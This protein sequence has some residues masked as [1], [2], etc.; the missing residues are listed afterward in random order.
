MDLSMEST[1][2]LVVQFSPWS[3]RGRG[4]FVLLIGLAGFLYIAVHYHISCIEK[5][6]GV[7]S[8]C[9]LETRLYGHRI[10]M[11]PLGTLS[12][13]E[14]KFYE[15]NVKSHMNDYILELLSDTGT[16]RLA[17][18]SSGYN[19]KKRIADAINTYVQ[20]STDTSFTV[21]HD[22]ILQKM[23]QRIFAGIALIGCMIV[24]LSRRVQVTIDLALKEV[25]MK[26]TGFLYDNTVRY[27]LN[28]INKFT[29]QE[30]TLPL[31]NQ[32]TLYRIEMMLINMDLIP[33]S[34]A[35]VKDNKSLQETVDTMNSFLNS[36]PREVAPLILR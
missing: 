1:D 5:S 3:W 2:R 14:V 27:P 24:I 7:A 33:L 9:S 31:R 22:P 36:K 16:T 30:K 4:I 20:Y 23:M 13:A 12:S 25:R 21:P 10:L 19:D 8:G 6:A 35:Y 34:N 26:K 11:S 18:P 17:G 29:I 15:Y 32:V 28:E